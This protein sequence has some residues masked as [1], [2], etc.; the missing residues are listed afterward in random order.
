[1]LSK[2][3]ILAEVFRQLDLTCSLNSRL[4]VSLILNLDDETF[5]TVFDCLLC[6]LKDMHFFISCPRLLFVGMWRVNLQHNWSCQY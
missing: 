3:E 4:V 2:G 1:M 5:P 6:S